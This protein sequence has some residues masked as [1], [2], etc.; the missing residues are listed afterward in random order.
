MRENQFGA[1]VHIRAA[2]FDMTMVDEITAVAGIILI[3]QFRS[4]GNPIPV[5][6]KPPSAASTCPVM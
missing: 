2:I 5:A 3:R 1:F 4:E 6:P